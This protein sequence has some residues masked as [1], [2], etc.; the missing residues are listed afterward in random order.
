M[1]GLGGM[2]GLISGFQ[3][4][5]QA[6]QAAGHA[7]IHVGEVANGKVSVTINGKL[8][9]TAVSISPEVT[10]DHELLEDLV[11]VAANAAISKAQADMAQRMQ[12]ATAGLP[13]PPGM[14]NGLL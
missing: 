14:L 4:Q 1:G 11:L 7:A 3:Q 6:A 12:E 13:I 2:G 10:T 5:M 8:E 9:V